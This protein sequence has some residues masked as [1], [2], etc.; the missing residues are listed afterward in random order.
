MTT[1]RIES[2]QE[3]RFI[4]QDKTI[5]TQFPMILHHKIKTNNKK[6]YKPMHKK[7]ACDSLSMLC[8]TNT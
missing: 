8:Y 5:I 7:S 6:R 4:S 1:T 2:H 3:I